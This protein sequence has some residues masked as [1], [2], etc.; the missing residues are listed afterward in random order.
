MA[1]WERP[2]GSD[3]TA[4]NVG[5]LAIELSCSYE[6]LATGRGSRQLNVRSDSSLEDLEPVLRY[7]ARTDDEERLMSVFRDID[8]WDKHLV[9]TI[10]DTLVTRAVHKRVKPARRIN[11]FA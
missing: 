4:F 11:E 3:P 8:D 9:L 1:Q 6:W 5:R 10:L 2:G 7:F